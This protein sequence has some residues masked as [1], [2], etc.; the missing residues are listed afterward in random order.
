MDVKKKFYLIDLLLSTFFFTPLVVLFWHG[1]FGVL[2]FLLLKQNPYFGPW[3][4]LTIGIIIQVSVCGFQCEI[5]SMVAS[6]SQKRLYLVLYNFIMATAQILQFRGLNDI[7]D[8]FM[9]PGVYDAITAT[10]TA[11]VILFGTRLMSQV[12]DMP[13]AVTLDTELTSDTGFQLDT[14]YNTEVGTE[15]C[16]HE[17]MLEKCHCYRYCLATKRKKK[18]LLRPLFKELNTLRNSYASV[19]YDYNK[20]T[21]YHSVVC[22]TSAIKRRLLILMGYD[23]FLVL[24]C[25]FWIIIIIIDTNYNILVL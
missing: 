3:L 20:F 8:Y 14:Y 6:R 4:I 18:L 15:Y 11:I 25:P 21:G 19:R 12:T 24:D 17:Y 5:K 10:C 13:L 22:N 23:L 1:T 9:G 2:D 16:T 7:Y